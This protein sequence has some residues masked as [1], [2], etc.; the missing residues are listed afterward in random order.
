MIEDPKFLLGNTL[1]LESSPKEG[2]QTQFGRIFL[3]DKIKVSG[4]LFLDQYE[5]QENG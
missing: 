2:F 3:T 1:H 5:H 4:Y